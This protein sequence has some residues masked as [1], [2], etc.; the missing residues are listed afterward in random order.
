MQFNY[1]VHFKR[2]PT[3]DFCKENEITEE[4]LQR[5][6]AGTVTMPL[7]EALRQKIRAHAGL[8]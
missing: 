6:E 1:L 7:T 4:D 8:L 2:L 3:P 5:N